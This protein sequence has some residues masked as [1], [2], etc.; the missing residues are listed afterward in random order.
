MAAPVCTAAE[1]RQVH[2]CR[3]WLL[4]IAVLHW[5]VFYLMT[6]AAPEASS[7]TLTRARSLLCL[8]VEPHWR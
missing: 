5:I 1:A 3:M 6:Q 7:G 2:W 8:F 4:A